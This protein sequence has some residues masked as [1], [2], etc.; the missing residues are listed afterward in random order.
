MQPGIPAS[1]S[2]TDLGQILFP[3]ETTP[4]AKTET[5]SKVETPT[6]HT[7]KGEPHPASPTGVRTDTQGR[8]GLTQ[9][10]ENYESANRYLNVLQ[11]RLTNLTKSREGATPEQNAKIDK[12]IAKVTGYIKTQQQ[13]VSS[14]EKQMSPP[15]APEL[16]VTVAPQ[17]QSQTQAPVAAAAQEAIEA[18][19]TAAPPKTQAAQSPSRM[20]PKEQAQQK[21]NHAGNMIAQTWGLAKQGDIIRRGGREDEIKSEIQPLKDNI[22]NI[23]RQLKNPQLKAKDRH[24]LQLD[25]V[26]NQNKLAYQERLLT[27]T[28]VVYNT[29]GKY[30]ET[31]NS[32]AK[33]APS[34]TS[35]EGRLAVYKALVDLEAAVNAGV[36]TIQLSTGE[37]KT[38]PD[39]LQ[40]ITK[41]EYGR[42]VLK[43]SSK[44][45]NQMAD[46]VY[47][48]TCEIPLQTQRNLS[49]ALNKPENREAT[50]KLLKNLIN[51]QEDSINSSNQKKVLDKLLTGIENPKERREIGKK[52]VNDHFSVADA[53]Q[54]FASIKANVGAVDDSLIC[55]MMVDQILNPRE[56]S[57]F[58]NGQPTDPQ[59]L[60]TKF[61]TYVPEQLA[62]LE[63]LT[64]TTEQRLDMLE[65]RG[66]NPNQ[67]ALSDAINGISRA[68]VETTAFLLEQLMKRTVAMENLDNAQLNRDLSE[69]FPGM[70]DGATEVSGS[71]NWDKAF[72]TVRNLSQQI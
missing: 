60:I 58:Y 7:P 66:P 48:A 15:P 33:N 72:E 13:F 69:A 26:K 54:F 64:N 24:G 1:G 4:A 42:Q 5:A 70:S 56:L 39:M 44:L 27:P 28:S 8:A 53:K 25:L 16:P 38:I 67:N 30:L 14:L 45:R 23:E 9:L 31:V 40:M 2:G 18:K 20:T 21:A 41:S 49:N 12:D 63:N 71:L 34:P 59:K 3:I 61:Q 37:S 22:T 46:L 55:E 17:P 6:V 11:G 65:L 68:G 29:K 32:S 50:D 51:K 47:R 57:F 19:S 62:N 36:T 43:H 52:I 35:R 10:Q